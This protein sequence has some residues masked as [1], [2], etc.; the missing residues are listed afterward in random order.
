MATE[1]TTR[2]DYQK[3]ERLG[4][5]PTDRDPS[6]WLRTVSR[7]FAAYKQVD[8]E[9]DIVAYIDGFWILNDKFDDGDRIKSLIQKGSCFIDSQFIGFTDNILYKYSKSNLN[10]G[11]KYF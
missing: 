3:I 10:P 7:T 1:V 6:A 8:V 4:L 9:K 11:S 5:L 2:K